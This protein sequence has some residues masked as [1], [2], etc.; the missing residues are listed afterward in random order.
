MERGTGSISVLDYFGRI[1]D[2][3]VDRHKKH[4]L[5]EIL[6]I[7]LCTMLVGGESFEDMVSFGESREEWLRRFIRLEHGI[8]SH[9]T[10]RRVFCLIKPEKF[11]E[12]VIEWTESI[13][14]RV[15]GEIVA[16]DGKS[17]RRTAKNKEEIP[18]Q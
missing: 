4:M 12:S 18:R 13:R 11:V 2:P 5:S 8:A 7:G 17:L 6:F 14:E 15:S 3:R 16:I 10:F 1:E 9:D